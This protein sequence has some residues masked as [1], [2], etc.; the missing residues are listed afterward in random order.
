[1]G[2]DN[3]VGDANISKEPIRNHAPRRAFVLARYRELARRREAEARKGSR[4]AG[5]AA[6]DTV[7][8]TMRLPRASSGTASSR[9]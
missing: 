3:K 2:R 1:M 9:G 8:P 5:R 6:G 7:P 4:F